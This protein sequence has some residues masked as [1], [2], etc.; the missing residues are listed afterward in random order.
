MPERDALR[1]RGSSLEDDHFRKKDRELIEK[2]RRAAAAEETRSDLSNAIGLDDP[3]L[4]QELHDLGFT[5]DT[6]GLLPVV[7]ILQMAWAEG[8]I[9]NA[10]RDLIVRFAR[11]RG[12]EGGSVADERLTQWMT[13][14]PAD[15]VFAR[16]G[17]LIRAVLDSGSGQ[18]GDLKVEDLLEYCESIASASGGILGLGR[19]SGEERTLLSEIAADLKGRHSG[20]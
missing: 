14:R 8:G 13:N 1:E 7:P 16:A 17:R 5:P 15:A 20:R 11:R 12:I 6:V 10:E 4:I 19:I 3:E 18:A 9:T 2:M